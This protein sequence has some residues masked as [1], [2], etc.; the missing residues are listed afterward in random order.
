LVAT[1]GTDRSCP[2]EGGAGRLR[3]GPRTSLTRSRF[4]RSG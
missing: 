4:G 3:S 1:A 2:V